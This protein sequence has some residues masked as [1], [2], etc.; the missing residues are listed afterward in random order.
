[1][2][3]KCLVAIEVLIPAVMWGCG[4]ETPSMKTCPVIYS[5]TDKRDKLQLVANAHQGVYAAVLTCN[6]QKPT[7]VGTFENCLDELKDSERVKDIFAQC[8]GN[9]DPTVTPSTLGEVVVPTRPAVRSLVPKPPVVVVQTT[10]VPLQSTPQYVVPPA[11]VVTPPEPV[12]T[13]PVPVVHVIPGPAP[14]VQPNPGPTPVDPSKPIS[15]PVEPPKPISNPVQPPK[16]I[17]KPVEPPKP[18]SRPIVPPVNPPH[19]GLVPVVGTVDTPQA[20]TSTTPPPPVGPKRL[21]LIPG[22][23]PKPLRRH[24][25]L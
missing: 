6:S 17:S 14:I 1:M 18:I 22:P 24:S 16:P 2:V 8:D 20:T 19:P 15:R 11:P 21:S 3:S 12:V 7:A 10:P 4:D 23:G 9:H 13:P 25:F 5:A